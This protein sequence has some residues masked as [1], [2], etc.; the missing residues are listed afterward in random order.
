LVKKSIKQKFIK[1]NKA[2]ELNELLEILS[3]HD[4]NMIKTLKLKKNFS[5]IVFLQSSLRRSKYLIQGA[6]QSI[7]DDNPT[8][9]SLAIRGHFETM[10]AL[11]LLGSKFKS[12]EARNIDIKRIDEVLNKLT[13]GVKL[14]FEDTLPDSFNVLT[15]ISESELNY[16][17]LTGDTVSFRDIYDKLSERCHPNGMGWIV[18]AEFSEENV[19]FNNEN[20]LTINERDQ[21]ITYLLTTVNCYI[22][23]YE[24]VIISLKSLGI[25]P[26]GFID[27]NNIENSTI[28]ENIIS[29][30]VQ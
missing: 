22:L 2:E 27:S 4:Q 17:K 3:F 30:A 19:K 21:L 28:T 23:F 26:K 5:P 29:K 11:G 10:A 25:D 12:F 24:N 1:I 14:R 20:K 9:L 15:M 7:Y 18:W 16:K 6:I 13:L 8:M